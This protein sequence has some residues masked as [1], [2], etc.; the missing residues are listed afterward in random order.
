MNREPVLELENVG[1]HFGAL[2]VMEGVNLTIAAGERHALIGPNGA[3][4]STLFN[5]ISG[6]FPP[7]AGEIRLRGQRIS[8]LPPHEIN[9][10]GLSRS[11]QITDRKSVV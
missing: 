11:F 1:K 7:T 10:L 2:K 4:K 6:M 9:R 8:G 3:G 5:M